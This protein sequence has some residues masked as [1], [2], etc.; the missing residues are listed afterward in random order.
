MLTNFD[1]TSRE[2]CVAARTVANTPQQALTLL[3]D[4][5]FVECARVFAARLVAEH[6]NQSDSNII[7]AAY[8]RAL[9]REVKPQENASLLTFLRTVR[10]SYKQRPDDAAK[11]IA[12]G[13]APV[14]AAA[15]PVELASWTTICRVILNLH[16][17]ITRY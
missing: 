8:E 16:E 13:N 7:D 14:A 15:D 17:T 5:S 6:R 11:L 1:A 10:D 12:I 9:G 4:P 3:N 2:D